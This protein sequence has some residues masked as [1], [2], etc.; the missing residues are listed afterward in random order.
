MLYD[1]MVK[2]KSLQDFDQI[3][4]SGLSECEVYLE[5]LAPRETMSASKVREFGMLS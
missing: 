5:A 2:A 1:S 3:T 4:A